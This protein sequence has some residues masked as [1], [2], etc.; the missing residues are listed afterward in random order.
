MNHELIDSLKK[1]YVMLHSRADRIERSLIESNT[2]D[3]IYW[4]DM[5]IQ[6]VNFI[7]ERLEKEDKK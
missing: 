5:T 4:C 2:S 3:A 7:K 1:N 6:A